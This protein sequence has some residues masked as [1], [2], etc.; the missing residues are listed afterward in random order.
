MNRLRSNVCCLILLTAAL[1]SS[2]CSQKAATRGGE[3]K[4]GSAT[5]GPE[6]GKASD[7]DKPGLGKPKE[8]GEA[9][10]GEPGLG[11]ASDLDKPVEE[12]FSVSCEHGKKMFECDECRYEV[13]VARARARLFE[14]GLL[15]RVR[16]T[17]ERVEFPILLN[18]E[19]QFDERRLTHVSFQTEGVVRRVYATLGDRVRRGQSLVEI[20]SVALGEA[21]GAYLET[22]A[23]LRLAGRSHERQKQLFA[24]KVSA[25]REFLLAG[26]EFESAQIRAQSA[27]G[28]LT[29]LGMG[30]EE[31]SGLRPQTALGR[32]IV[33]APNDGTLLSLHAVPGEIVKAEESLIT[34]GDVGTVWVWAALHERELARVSGQ[35]AAGKLSA[36]V[37]V[38]AYPGEELPGTVDLISL[39][40]DEA[41]R[42]VKVRV[43]LENKGGKLRAGMFADVKVFLRG[44][45]ETVALPRVAVLEDEGRSFVFIRHHG[46][47]YV[48]R[49]IMAGRRWSGWV[50]IT[51][52]LK[53]GEEIVS[54][55]SFLLK[56][57]VLRAKMGAGCAD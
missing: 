10:A 51:A 18:G 54:D 25:E 55:G 34:L 48:R 44:D 21:Q 49:P 52:G 15:K 17:R 43:S 46:D 47:Y 11:K 26:Q 45:E 28:R 57:D 13:G 22:Q 6:A 39:S 37:S 4:P 41:S 16:A 30:A 32:M 2:A 27:A 5:P 23:T 9:P 19:V 35:Q 31:I 1:G 20:E 53:G 12:L 3:E 29:R 42:T 36:L 56:S 33:R 7:L 38:K 8:P 24:E 50:E 14:E 40:M